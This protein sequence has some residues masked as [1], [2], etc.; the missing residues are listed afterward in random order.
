MDNTPSS[1]APAAPQPEELKP[2]TADSVAQTAAA[3][4]PANPEASKK[5]LR[6]NYRPSHRA[7]FIGIAVVMA[8]LAVN[9]VIIGLVLKKQAS[10]NDLAAKGQVSISTSDLNQLGINRGNVG[11]AG[12]Q[13][14]VAPN[15]QFKGNLAVDGSTSISGQVVLNN[16]LTGTEANITQLQAGKASLAQ[17]EVNGDGTI[18]TLN[19]RKDLVVA[20]ITQLQGAVT[21]NQLLTV[22]NN[23]NVVGNL[24]IGGTFSARA[25]AAN[26]TLTVGGHIISNG[27]APAIGRGGSALGSNGTVS[28]S[29][30]DAAGTIAI[31]IGAGAVAGTLANVAF[32]NQYGDT[33]R[34]VIT[35]VGIGA[36]FYVLNMSVGGFS[37]G[38]GSGLPPGGYQLNYIVVQ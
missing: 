19:L 10:Q 11:N 33:P 36:N 9:A 27:P 22:N 12:V 14:T 24:N 13:L 1:P 25:L 6:R 38:V 31:N 28:I 2:R 17:L 29:G 7:T 8:I 15:A 5:L 4:P 20:G 26:S 3:A 32:H 18:S 37:V 35:P 30:S 34:V 21:I 16:K 23:L